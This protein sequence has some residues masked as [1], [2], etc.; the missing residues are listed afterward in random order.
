MDGAYWALKLAEAKSFTV[1]A[2]SR[3]G[4]RESYPLEATIRYEFP[5]R[6]GLPPVTLLW[7]DGG[8]RPPRPA[9]WPETREFLGSNGTIF[10]GEKGQLTFGALT[11]GTGP[12]Q[13]GPRFIP[14]SLGDSY[15]R[16]KPTIPRIRSQKGRWVKA[17]RH[18][19]DW[20]RACLGESPACS[21]FEISGPLTEIVLLGNVAL[22]CGEKIHWDR[23]KLEV[24]NVPEANRHVRREYRAGWSL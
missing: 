14:E 1:E 7:Y 4:T 8:R 22:T 2:E 5:A 19:E 13:A 12:G 16:P 20:L 23:D 24:T 18:V 21:R 15:R 10:Y 3:G 6:A 17:G 11:A 9:E